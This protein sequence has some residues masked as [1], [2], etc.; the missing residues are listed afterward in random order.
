[1]SPPAFGQRMSHLVGGRCIRAGKNSILQARL[2]N[3]SL[4]AISRGRK[5]AK[6]QTRRRARTARVDGLVDTGRA[7]D[8]HSIRNFARK[9]ARARQRAR[10]DKRRRA[11]LGACE[12]RTRLRG[13]K[14][15]DHRNI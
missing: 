1:M 2:A 9:I 14:A 7:I 11:A 3:D 10:D 5:G 6:M 15:R 4:S 8:R 13:I 12:H